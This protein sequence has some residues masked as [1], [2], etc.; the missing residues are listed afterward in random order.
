MGDHCES[1][2]NLT[3]RKY[4]KGLQLSD[5][6]IKEI[7]E[8]GAQVVSFLDLL[9]RHIVNPETNIMPRANQIEQNINEMR[10]RM[11]KDRIARLNE[12]KG[13]VQAGLVFIDMLTSFEKM[14]DHSYNVAQVLSGVR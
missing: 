8:I 10:R 11:R 1:L 12:G 5:R 3:R 2:L 4:D 14:G 13:G 6:T 9:S 7:L